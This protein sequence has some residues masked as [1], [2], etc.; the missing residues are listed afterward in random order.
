MRVVIVS[1]GSED[2][3]GV[4]GTVADLFDEAIDMEITLAAVTWP[5]RRSP[6]WDRAHEERPV[7]WGDLHAAVAVIVSQ[8]FL[9]AR[10]A[11]GV[12]GRRCEEVIASGDPASEVLQILEDRR[13]DL[14]IVAVTGGPK[15][16]D[17]LRWVSLLT[18]Q[19]ACPVV[20]MHAPSATG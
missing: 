19:S 13:A 14:A 18:A 10:S 9:E 8:V 11:L 17:V 1:D 2:G 7:A 3:L 16:A 4:L 6:I 12:H 20:V 15:R 5:E